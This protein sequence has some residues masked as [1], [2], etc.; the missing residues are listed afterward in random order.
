MVGFMMLATFTRDYWV[1][2]LLS[3]LNGQ[4]VQESFVELVLNELF[5]TL[6]D[7]VLNLIL[8]VIHPIDFIKKLLLLLACLA[9]FLD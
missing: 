6:L 9:D 8:L 4:D 7:L 2:F 1:C 5:V 3:G